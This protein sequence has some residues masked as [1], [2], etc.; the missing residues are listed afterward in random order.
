M[1]RL[2]IRDGFEKRRRQ[3]SRDVLGESFTGT[4]V[5]DCYAGYEAHTAGAKQKCLT[6]LARTSGDWQKLTS[7]RTA[8]FGFFDE[9]REFVRQAC[10][11]HRQHQKKELS[12]EQQAAKTLWLRERLLRLMTCPV[13]HEKGVTLQKRILKHQHELCCAR[14]HLAI[15]AKRAQDAWRR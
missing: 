11:F 13:T 4:L 9:I 8:D 1:L 12:E 14:S 2:A 7:S 10:H 6:H 15:A 5:T 3:V